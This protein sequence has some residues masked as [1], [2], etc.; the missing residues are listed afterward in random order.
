M[1]TH[2]PHTAQAL[3]YK[4][5]SWLQTYRDGTRIGRSQ[6]LQAYG[7]MYCADGSADTDGA[8]EERIS[9]QRTPM[10][11][12]ASRTGTKR[13]LEAMRANGWGLLVSAKG[14]L[15][16]ED[17]P[18]MLDN[19]AWTA[20]THGEEFDERA[21]GKAFDL[22]GEKA[23]MVVVPDIVAG[24]L[25]SLEFSLTWL[26][27]IQGIP[28]VALL[29]VQDGMVPDDVRDLLNPGVGI[30]VGGSTE[31]KLRTAHSWGLLARRR[32][33]HLHIGRVNSA[34]RILLCSAAAGAHSVDGT[35]VS[36]YEKTCAPLTAAVKYGE[37]QAD[38]L[39]PNGLDFDA[40]P[41]DCAWPTDLA[42]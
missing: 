1:L 21:F 19:G 6:A 40:A 13:N 35:S 20:F 23:K 14:V 22:L 7:E 27:R 41:F 5:P 34:K 15:R 9:V 2:P 3:T 17:F 33:C 38:F 26:N 18:Y 37:D 30:F 24:G 28:G 36:V 29:A 16:T 39:S 12:Y 11:P 4:S 8:I 25:R 32:R 10:I 42:R 31:W